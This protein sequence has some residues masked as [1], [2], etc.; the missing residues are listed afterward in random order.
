MTDYKLEKIELWRFIWKPNIDV[1]WV[2]IF[3]FDMKLFMPEIRSMTFR[4][5][6]DQLL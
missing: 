2:T 4:W 6:F 3:S 5:V 1:N